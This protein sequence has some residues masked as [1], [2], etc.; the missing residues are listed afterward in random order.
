MFPQLSMNY[1]FK[2]DL[3]LDPTSLSLF[4]TLT[5]WIW[6]FKPLMGF[7]VDSFSICGSKKLSYLVLCSFL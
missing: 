7:T 3:K 5:S 6:L 4:D 2:D 1:F